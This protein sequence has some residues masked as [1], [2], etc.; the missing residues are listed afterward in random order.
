MP[1]KILFLDIDGT[2]L[3]SDH[4][5]CHTTKQAI[6][7]LQQQNVHV[8][9]AT[10]RPLH[11]IMDLA[12]K[13]NVKSYIGYNGAYAIHE[14]QSIVN[15]PMKEKTIT[16]FV[17]IAERFNHELV[18]YTYGNNFFTAPHAK[19]TM[20][21]KTFFD[22]NNN[23]VFTEEIAAD[24]LGTTVVN[25]EAGEQSQYEISPR[26]SL[27]QINVGGLDHSYDV[28]REHVNKGSAVQSILKHLNIPAEHAI[29]FGDG[30]NDKEMFQSVGTSFVMENGHQ[31]VKKYAKYETTSNDHAGIYNGLKKIG[32]IE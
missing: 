29:A 4:T 7:T 10:G 24:I 1:Y 11:A 31:D 5:V 30:L 17:H 21:F 26:I 8:F 19:K 6:K 27:A 22:L 12:K 15:E 23:D 32:L 16:K 18:L 13:L 9:F 14:K 25:V 2:L 3:Q 20:D 28:I